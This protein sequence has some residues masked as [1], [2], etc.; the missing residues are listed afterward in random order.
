MEFPPISKF[1]GQIFKKKNCFKLCKDL[2]NYCSYCTNCT[3]KK[4]I[5]FWIFLQS[6]TSFYV[7]VINIVAVV[8][9]VVD[10]YN[11][12]QFISLLFILVQFTQQYWLLPI[13]QCCRFF[14][15]NLA[16][17]IEDANPFLQ[18]D[19]KLL[20]RRQRHLS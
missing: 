10:S 2:N 6:T 9:V 17:R 15:F 13:C 20:V 7:F 11:F 19:S 18:P 3:L 5:Y 4:N 12:I 8:V 1:T 14:V 16:S